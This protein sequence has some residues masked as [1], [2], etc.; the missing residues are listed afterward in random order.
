[1]RQEEREVELTVEVS[2]DH[3]DGGDSMATGHTH[4]SLSGQFQ[5]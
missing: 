3:V 5:F 1:M 2:E 4:H